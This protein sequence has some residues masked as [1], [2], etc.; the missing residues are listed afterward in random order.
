MLVPFAARARTATRAAVYGGRDRLVQQVLPAQFVAA[1]YPRSTVVLNDIG[2]VAFYSDARILD[3]VGLGSMEPLR[4]ARQPGGLSRQS[5]EA[6]ARDAGAEL[7][8]LLVP[9]PEIQAITPD[10]WVEVA[11]VF[12]ARDAVYRHVRNRPQV[13]LYACRGEGPARLLQQRVRR[14]LAPRYR[15]LGVRVVLRRLDQEPTTRPPTGPRRE[16]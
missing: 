16:G 1:H 4:L 2:A 9:W 7:A 14:F 3:L 11:R 5:V 12:L 15:K 8:I 6:W 13:R 10:S